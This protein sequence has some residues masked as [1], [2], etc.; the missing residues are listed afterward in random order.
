MFS[1]TSK[2]FEKFL[3]DDEDLDDTLLNSVFEGRMNQLNFTDA[4]DDYRFM[5]E[6]FGL[7]LS[8]I[9]DVKY[10]VFFDLMEDSSV[11]ILIVTDKQAPAGSGSE[12]AGTQLRA[13]YNNIDM[14]NYFIKVRMISDEQ[15]GT[16]V[17]SASMRCVVTLLNDKK[18]IVTG[19]HTSQN[20]YHGLQAPFTFIGIG[21][22]NNFIEEFSIAVYSDIGKRS[23]RTWTPVIPK[24]VLFVNIDM[25]EN[26]DNW[27]LTLLLNPTGKIP[28]ILLCD[29][30][31]LLVLGLV[32]I[33]FHLYEKAEDE[34]E[35]QSVK[36]FNFF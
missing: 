17:M 25:S 2:S 30:V 29:G 32:I 3:V 21:R 5:G 33:V 15:V 16:Q 26:P 35:K 24:S 1:P 31:F 10:A 7:L 23:M 36:A 20:A 19:G 34:R 14:S 4:G 28:L 22:S 13:I 18:V 8:S 27:G 12:A 11:D 6:E 9:Q